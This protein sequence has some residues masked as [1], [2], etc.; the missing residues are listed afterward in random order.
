MPSYIIDPEDPSHAVDTETDA[1]WP[2]MEASIEV[3]HA[4]DNLYIASI[5]DQEFAFHTATAL[6]LPTTAPATRLVVVAVGHEVIGTT[7]ASYPYIAAVQSEYAEGG[8]M[9]CSSTPV[10]EGEEL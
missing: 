5:N 3:A 9:T 2:F 6:D 7:G 10:T 4:R 1:R 8:L